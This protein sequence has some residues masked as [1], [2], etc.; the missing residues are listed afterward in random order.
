MVRF[1]DDDLSNAR[2]MRLEKRL[3][4]HEKFRREQKH[5]DLFLSERLHEAGAFVV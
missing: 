4:T 1:V 2:G 3:M 5:V